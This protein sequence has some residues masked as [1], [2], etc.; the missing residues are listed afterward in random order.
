[1]YLSDI[2]L[3]LLQGK[4]MQKTFWLEGRKGLSLALLNCENN[5]EINVQTADD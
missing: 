4:G 3:I 2:W 1:V 5:P